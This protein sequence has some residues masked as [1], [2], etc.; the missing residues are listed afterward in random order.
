MEPG[1]DAADDWQPSVKR[2]KGKKALPRS[3]PE[4]LPFDEVPAPAPRQSAIFRRA[5]GCGTCRCCRLSGEPCCRLAIQALAAQG[6]LGAQLTQAGAASLGQAVSVFWLS[7]GRW[8]S[9]RLVAFNPLEPA[10]LV[11]YADGDWGAQCAPLAPPGA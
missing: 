2:R 9:G 7:E 10:F 11:L 4:P 3:P 1:S 8:F 5:A 6:H